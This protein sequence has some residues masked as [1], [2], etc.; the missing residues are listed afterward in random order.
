MHIF[1]MNLYIN[2]YNNPSKQ[3]TILISLRKQLALGY[4]GHFPHFQGPCLALGIMI[5]SVWELLSSI[6]NVDFTTSFQLSQNQFVHVKKEKADN[7]CFKVLVYIYM[8]MLCIYISLRKVMGIY[9]IKFSIISLMLHNITNSHNISHH[10]C[11][12]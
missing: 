9:Y 2:L 4:I 8:Y 6:M 12:L 3:A 7:T 10:K 1:Q 11:Q 5:P